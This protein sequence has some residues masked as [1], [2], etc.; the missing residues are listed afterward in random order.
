MIGRLPRLLRLGPALTLLP[1]VSFLLAGCGFEPLYGRSSPTGAVGPQLNQVEIAIIP[2]RAGQQ[3]RNFLID[4]FYTNGRPAEPVHRL[5]VTLET[6]RRTLG[7]EKDATTSRAQLAMTARY[8]L[9]DIRANKAVFQ[10]NS[11]VVTDFNVLL[12]PY[13]SVAAETDAQERGLAQL[14]DDITT[15]IA[16]VLRRN[17]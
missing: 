12:S 6:I 10:G 13:G 1:V 3:L 2:D 4:R 7:I 17:P 8:Q 5:D 16:L 11:R 15:R 14:S 9:W